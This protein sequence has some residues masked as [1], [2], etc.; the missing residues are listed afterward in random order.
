MLDYFIG[1][2]AVVNL[3]VLIYI[4]RSLD[5]VNEVLRRPYVNWPLPVKETS[6]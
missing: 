3:V 4:A 1:G 6:R 2:I 5:D